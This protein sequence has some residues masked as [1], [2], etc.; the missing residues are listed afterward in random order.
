MIKSSG[1]DVMK[2]L[3]ITP[4]FVLALPARLYSGTDF[5][6]GTAAYEA[7]GY[8]TALRKF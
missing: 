6:K 5:D 1:D 8:A 2:I 3:P 7:E 4:L